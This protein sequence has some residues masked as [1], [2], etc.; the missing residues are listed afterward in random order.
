VKRGQRLLQPI[1][2][3]RFAAGRHGRGCPGAGF[4][5]LPAGRA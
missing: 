4:H 5:G 2:E 1:P 3:V